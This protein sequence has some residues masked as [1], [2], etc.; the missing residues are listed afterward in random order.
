MLDD[1]VEPAVEDVLVGMSLAIFPLGVRG[2]WNL[3]VGSFTKGVL[4]GIHVTDLD[5][6]L[7][8]TVTAANND[9][10]TGKGSE[11][12]EDGHAKLLEDWDVLGRTADVEAVGCCGG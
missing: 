7:R 3:D 1:P 2:L 9:W 5:V 8:T 6:E 12:F 11:W 4:G 10:L